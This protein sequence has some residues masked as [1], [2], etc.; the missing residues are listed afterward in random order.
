[1]LSELLIDAVLKVTQVVYEALHSMTI[2]AWEDADRRARFP[3]HATA[4]RLSIRAKVL[5]KHTNPVHC[6]VTALTRSALRDF[7]C[8]RMTWDAS[9]VVCQR[10]TC[11]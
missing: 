5:L 2:K 7:C 6:W 4:G 8:D 9:P 3:T 1:M 11:M 10:G